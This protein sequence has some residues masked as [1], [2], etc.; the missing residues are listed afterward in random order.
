MSSPSLSP[1]MLA[2]TPISSPQIDSDDFHNG[3]RNADQPNHLSRPN[4][5]RQQSMDSTRDRV[6]VVNPPTPAFG[7]G[8]DNAYRYRPFAGPP[9]APRLPNNPQPVFPGAPMFSPPGLGFIS[10]QETATFAFNPRNP[11]SL[12]SRKAA[13]GPAPEGIPLPNTT[14]TKNKH[15]SGPA[16]AWLRLFVICVQQ[17]YFLVLLRTPSLYFTRISRLFEDAN[18]G[19]PDILRLVAEQPTEQDAFQ[20][21]S[22]PANLPTRILQFRTTWNNF[23]DSL[24][25]EWKTQNVVSALLLSAILTMLQID[26]AANDA[27]T[28]I[29]ALLALI[30][31]FVSLLFGSIYIVRFGT[32][33]RMYKAA[34]WAMDAEAGKTNIL[35]SAWILLALPSVWLAWS[36]IFFVVCIMAFVWRTGAASDAARE[37]LGLSDGAALAMRVLVTLEL[38]LAV[39]Y[40]GCVFRTFATYGEEMDRTWR[41]RVM[42]ARTPAEKQRAK[43]LATAQ[44][45]KSRAASVP[46][47]PYGGYVPSDIPGPLRPPSDFLANRDARMLRPVALPGDLNDRHPLRA[48]KVIELDPDA[49]VIHA[50]PF[51]LA[52]PG[53]QVDEAEWTRLAMNL[54]QDATSFSN[55]YNI[56]EIE[57]MDSGYSVLNERHPIVEH[58][59]SWNVMAAHHAFVHNLTHYEAVIVRLQSLSVE[60]EGG[61]PPASGL[62]PR[63]SVY[64]VAGSE[65]PDRTFRFLAPVIEPGVE[66]KV[67]VLRDKDPYSGQI[68][69]WSVWL[70]VPPA[71]EYPSSELGSILERDLD[72]NEPRGAPRRGV[73]F[74]EP[75]TGPDNKIDQEGVR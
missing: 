65:T 44:N 26:A 72:E 58:I 74:A 43:R 71:E 42:A 61:S 63:Y 62:Q 57:S 56:R 19:L 48:V 11:F 22:T 27:L 37:G 6:T 2:S 21:Y 25:R 29:T 60:G 53:N 55:Q 69:R 32:M 70:N 33:R 50:Y 9:P 12:P 23:I 40:L 34:C 8:I 66:G 35:W 67:A 49:A 20:I 10:S 52:G 75:E 39:M 3:R 41:E 28:R 59:R 47:A 7:L 36:M 51:H 73:W 5:L 64:L 54:Y 4:D 45:G 17:A 38:L 24:M 13:P 68:G 1:A 18:V 16:A 14:T 15:N 30:G 31:T 46:S